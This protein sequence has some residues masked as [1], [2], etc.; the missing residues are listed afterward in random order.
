MLWVIHCIDK[1]DALER[2]LAA[3]T[4]HREYLGSEPIDIV[5]SG[6]L[7]DDTNEKMI[8]SLFLVEAE[9]RAEIEE[10]QRNDPLFHADV[11]ATVSVNVF[12]RRQ[13]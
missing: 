1:L 9:S 12:Y 6:P 13:G 7:M 2:R 11:W 10:F 8:G 5:M 4:R 3:I